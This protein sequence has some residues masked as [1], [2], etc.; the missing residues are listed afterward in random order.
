MLTP[1]REGLAWLGLAPSRLALSVSAITL[2]LLCNVPMLP[3]LLLVRH[4]SASAF[5]FPG[6]GAGARARIRVH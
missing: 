3:V 6:A 4:A 5:A 2:L 1:E